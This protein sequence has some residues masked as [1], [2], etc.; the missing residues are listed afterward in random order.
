[1]DRVSATSNNSSAMVLALSGGIGGAKLAVGLA[2]ALAPGQLLVVAN[3]G[4]DFEHLG[5]NICPDLDT[6]MY[7]LAGLHDASK[8]WGLAGDTWSFMNALAGLGGESWFRL[9]DADLAKHVE[10]T[11]RLKAGESLS[12]IT[13]DFC[14]RLR[15][16]TKLLPMSD[17]PVRTLVRTADAVLPFQQYFV[18]QRCAPAVRGFSFQGSDTARPTAALM[19][20]LASHTLRAVIVCPSNPFISIDPILAL[21]G[22]RA[23]L[24][25]C[26]AP[27]IAVSPIVGGRALKGPTVKMMRELKLPV[28]ATTVARHYG[29]LLH[30]YVLDRQDAAQAQDIEVPV[31]VAQTLMQSLADKE[32]LAHTVLAFADELRRKPLARERRSGAVDGGAPAGERP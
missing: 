6:L 30:G 22:V 23:A 13:A 19:D 31:R 27:V 29:A 7:T 10:R 26:R 3:T 32:A 14:R 5:L 9:G 1:M 21:P 28:T 25:A 18:A 11:R 12:A 24:A 17:Q 4:D 8:G 20:A 2:R 15:V 16:A